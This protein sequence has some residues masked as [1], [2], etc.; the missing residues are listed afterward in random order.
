MFVAFLCWFFC[1]FFSVMAASCWTCDDRQKREKWKNKSS[2][3]R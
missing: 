3:C 1:L 2:G